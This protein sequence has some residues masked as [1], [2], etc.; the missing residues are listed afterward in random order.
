MK[1]ASLLRGIAEM[2][3]LLGA[4]AGSVH[5]EIYRGVTV[6]LIS[7]LRVVISVKRPFVDIVDADR[8]RA[9]CLMVC[10]PV[11]ESLARPDVL[12]SRREEA[13]V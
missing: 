6:R 1:R 2:P 3:A 8:P 4:C 9:D 10:C 5:G 12:S 11:I 13:C 7:F